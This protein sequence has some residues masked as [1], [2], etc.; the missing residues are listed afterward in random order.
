[1]L[2]K[3]ASGIPIDDLP[4]KYV[5]YREQIALLRKFEEQNRANKAKSVK[6]RMR[7]SVGKH[8]SNNEETRRELSQIQATLKK[9]R[10]TNDG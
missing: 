2:I 9:G 5:Q 6:E 4:E 1:M 10:E 7:K 8:V 3:N